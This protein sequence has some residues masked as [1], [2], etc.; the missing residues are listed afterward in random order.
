ML[1]LRTAPAGKPLQLGVQVRVPARHQALSL[2][3]Y[4]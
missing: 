4:M 1:R 2:E 3:A